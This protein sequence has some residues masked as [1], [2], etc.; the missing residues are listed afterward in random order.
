MAKV[1]DVAPA[2]TVTLAPTMTVAVAFDF[3][4]TTMPPAG[5]GP[6]SFAVPVTTEADPPTTAVGLTEMA[7]I[8]GGRTVRTAAWETPNVVAV[9]VT[10]VDAAT[11]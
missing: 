1:A 7:R 4:F 3:N 5:A 10:G 9:I 11:A 8:F 6:S 2:G